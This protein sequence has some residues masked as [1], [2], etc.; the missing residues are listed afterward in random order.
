MK[1]RQ[2]A[3]L[4]VV[5]IMFLTFLASYVTS[6]LVVLSGFE[7]LENSQVETQVGR[8]TN[9]LNSQVTSLTVFLK[10]GWAD[11]DDS[12]QFIQDNNTNYITNNLGDAGMANAN[13]NVIFYINSTGQM[14][15]CEAYNNTG[16][17]G[18]QALEEL[19]NIILN[20]SQIWKFSD[21]QASAGGILCTSA[22]MFIISSAPIL[23][24]EAKGPIAGTLIWARS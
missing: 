2:R 12:Y 11:W 16:Q 1:L 17:S 7:K 22:N 3:I 18:S 19:S 4:I 9:A 8:A 14:R 6:N 21:I 13:V 20:N 24:S 23:T 5:S 15:Y 10:S